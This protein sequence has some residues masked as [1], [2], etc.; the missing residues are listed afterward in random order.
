MNFR[1]KKLLPPDLLSR[2]YK[3]EY[4]IKKDR[5]QKSK[6]IEPQL[7]WRSAYVRLSEVCYL[8]ITLR[9]FTM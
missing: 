9:P 1:A 8:T 7:S 6:G 3:R 5:R 4:I 2:L